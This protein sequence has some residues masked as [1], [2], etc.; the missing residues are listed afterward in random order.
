VCNLNYPQPSF[1]NYKTIA[2]GRLARRAFALHEFPFLIE[3]ILSSEE[4]GGRTRSLPASDAQTL[5]DVIDEARSCL[6]AIVIIFWLNVTSARFVDQALHAPDLS[7]GTRKQCLK[8]LYRTCGHHA[9]LPGALKVPVTY[10]QTTHVV[11]RGGYAD[12]SKGRYRDQ[13]VAVKAIRT[14]SNT[15]L[16]KVIN[17]GCFIFLYC[18]PMTTF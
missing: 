10:D 12:V 15:E 5:I 6:L 3:A 16:R 4:E 11:Y 13:D 2:C 7:P 8:L 9:L 17:V 18:G 1:H 14:Y